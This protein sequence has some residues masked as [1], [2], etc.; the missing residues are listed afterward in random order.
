MGRL[1]GHYT[2]GVRW[3]PLMLLVSACATAPA[4]G[5]TT[6]PPTT[7][8]ALALGYGGLA[9]T[10][11][12]L[13]ALVE[14]DFTIGARFLLQYPHAYA[15]PIVAE[16]GDGRFAMGLAD[17]RWG[18]GGFKRDGA[19]VLYV[20][21]G[22]ARLVFAPREPLEPSRW[23]HLAVVKRGAV[24]TVHVDGEVEGTLTITRA[25]RVHGTLRLGRRT[26]GRP[27]D[28]SGYAG[29]HYG[30]VDDVVVLSRALAADEV[31]ALA[32]GPP[33]GRE[34]GLLA[35]LTFDE[36]A[37]GVV[38]LDGAATLVPASPDRDG[39]ADAAHIPLPALEVPLRL[40]FPAGEAWLVGQGPDVRG[41]SHN[42]FAS[43]CWDFVL[44]EDAARSRGRAVLAATPG[45]LV[46]VEDA[47]RDGGPDA[48]HI[49]IRAGDEEFVSYMH[50]ERRSVAGAF[51]A[52]LHPPDLPEVMA[53]RLVGRVGDTGAGAGNFHLHFAVGNRTAFHPEFVTVPVAFDG[54][55][56]STDRGRSW[57]AV[58]RGIPRSGE[59][60]RVPRPGVAARTPDPVPSG[61]R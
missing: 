10:E 49:M 5:P 60:V 21:L 1:R 6:E 7:T 40:P 48:N 61:L 12:P 31:M 52:Q 36:G 13:D 14:G 56:V 47:A 41:G 18:R 29:Q 20:E 11:V 2:H 26:D 39:E 59:W 8:R 23:R 27:A 44:A 58:A 24:L 17:Y 3:L 46:F 38:R 55:E 43:F 35:A 22:E 54:Y 51:S 25:A 53:G 34:A 4:K 37:P 15:G 45:R 28:R 50:L 30:L 9:D 16:N 19:A 42:G 33:T 32:A 57:R